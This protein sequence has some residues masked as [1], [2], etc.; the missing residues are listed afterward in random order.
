MAYLFGFLFLVFVGFY[1]SYIGLK[2]YNWFLLSQF[3]QLPHLSLGQFMGAGIALTM[4]LPRPMGSDLDLEKSK[5]QIRF[6]MYTLVVPAVLF[7][8]GAILRFGFGV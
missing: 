4:L 8:M 5:D 7:L 6:T 2:L 3:H 1:D